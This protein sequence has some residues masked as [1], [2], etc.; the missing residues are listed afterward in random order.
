LVALDAVQ[1]VA[2]FIGYVTA[3]A[4]STVISARKRP[5]VI[6]KAFPENFMKLEE[7]KTGFPFVIKSWNEKP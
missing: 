7:E 4:R 2:A 6:P 3:M 1:I 5:D